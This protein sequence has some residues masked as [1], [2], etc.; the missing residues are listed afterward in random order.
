MSEPRKNRRLIRRAYRNLKLGYACVIL[1]LLVSPALAV[2][3]YPETAKTLFETGFPVAMFFVGYSM[4]K[5][6]AAA[7][8]EEWAR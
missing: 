1:L 7:R 5:L 3:G 2:L 6:K 4:G 8:R